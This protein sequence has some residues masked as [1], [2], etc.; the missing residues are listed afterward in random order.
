MF[1][2][3]G[4]KVLDFPRTHVIDFF[5]STVP[6]FPNQ[7]LLLENAEGGTNFEWKS[8][9]VSRVMKNLNKNCN[10]KFRVHFLTAKENPQESSRQKVT[11]NEFSVRVQINVQISETIFH[12][13]ESL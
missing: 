12:F 9:L 2:Y 4:P 8:V 1:A 13:K 5:Y 6:K 7:K 3:S 10:T 11:A